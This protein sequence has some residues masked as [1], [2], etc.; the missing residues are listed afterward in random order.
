MR[1]DI[2]ICLDDDMELYSITDSGVK[3]LYYQNPEFG[4]YL[5]KLITGSFISVH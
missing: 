1:T 2:A 4:F 3:Q 5:V